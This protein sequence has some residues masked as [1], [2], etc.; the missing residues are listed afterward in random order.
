MSPEGRAV[1]QHREI[2]RQ[3][4]ERQKRKQ[5]ARRH[6]SYAAF[7]HLL[8]AEG[9]MRAGQWKHAEQEAEKAL[10]IHPRSRDALQIYTRCLIRSGKANAAIPYLQR[11]AEVDP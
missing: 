3:R 11:L 10:R 8:E 1:T 2:K 5:L 4:R 7:P 9:A 6:I